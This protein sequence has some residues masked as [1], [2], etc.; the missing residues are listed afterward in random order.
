MKSALLKLNINDYLKGFVVAVI[1][2]MLTSVLSILQS[3]GAIEW[4]WLFWQPTVYAALIAGISYLL[5]NIL[6]NSE[7][8]FLKSER[9]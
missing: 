2:A 9:K 1:T 3:G 6:T 5:K 8:Q 4:T 7:D